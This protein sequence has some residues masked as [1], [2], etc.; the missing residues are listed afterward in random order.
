KVKCEG[1]DGL[2]IH[3]PDRFALLRDWIM[4]ALLD[5]LRMPHLPR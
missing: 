5:A 3:H 1:S 4:V 2:R